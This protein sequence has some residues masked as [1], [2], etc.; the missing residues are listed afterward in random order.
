MTDADKPTDS[1][2]KPEEVDVES[3]T[4]PEGKPVE[5]PSG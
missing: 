3:G 5:N 2:T 1:T 4:D